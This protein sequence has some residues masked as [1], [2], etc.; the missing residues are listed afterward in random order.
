MAFNTGN[1]NNNNKGYSPSTYST[2]T[3][4][5][6]EGIDPSALGFSYYQRMLK[7]SIA[8]MLPMK[9]NDE[10]PQYDNE[11]AV[12]IYLLPANA[13]VFL[14]EIEEFMRDPYGHNNLGVV[15]GRN[16]NSGLIVIS[17][18]KELGVNETNLIIRR[19]NSNGDVTSS[20]AYQF[21]ND[22][23]YSSIRNYNEDT[24]DYSNAP[25]A[26]I[27]LEILCTHLRE[28]I[29][30]STYASAYSNLEANKRNTERLYELTKS[31]NEGAGSSKGTG[32]TSF[33]SKNKSNNSISNSK[34]RN[35]SS[36]D[37][38]AEEIEG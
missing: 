21:N 24:K 27:E 15:S 1:Q 36:L 20:A 23:Y 14:K 6:P 4:K 13:M 33:F 31:L 22:E 18:G 34:P 7:I 32:G 11:N 9:E 5:N 28:F 38:L 17:N 8:P 37:Q 25:H 35:Q 30:S 10:Y 12:S 16:E 3:F 19:I 26:N 2:Y 29:N